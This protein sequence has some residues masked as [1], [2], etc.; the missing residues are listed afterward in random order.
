MINPSIKDIQTHLEFLGYTVEALKNHEAD[1]LICRHGIRSN[2]SVRIVKDLVIVQARYV[3]KP[4][5]E[6]VKLYKMIEAINHDTF[7][8]KWYVPTTQEGPDFRIIA[9]FYTFGYVKETFGTLLELHEKE[10]REHIQKF[11]DFDESK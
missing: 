1:T 7:V 8:T 5:A 4:I 6:S 11:T 9:E 3:T 2:L 10:C